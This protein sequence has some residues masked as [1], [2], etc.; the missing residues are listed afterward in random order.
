MA[1]E[2]S[3]ARSTARPSVQ[4]PPPT[5]DWSSIGPFTCRAVPVSV[6]GTPAVAMPVGRD[7]ARTPIVT[8]VERRSSARRTVLE[9]SRRSPDFVVSTISLAL[10]EAGTVRA[11]FVPGAWNSFD[12]RVAGS[13]TGPQR[14]CG[15]HLS[16]G[17]GTE[18]RYGIGVPPLKTS[19]TSAVRPPEDEKKNVVAT[20]PSNIK[21][22]RFVAATALSPTSD[23]ASTPPYTWLRVS[24]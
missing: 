22:C 17:S 19:S 1:N 15:D 6:S 20:L 8:H 5:F 4:A 21:T 10:P 18:T 24:A 14:W 11:S 23:S 13:T 9:G 12:I 3:A 7:N 16:S 2:R